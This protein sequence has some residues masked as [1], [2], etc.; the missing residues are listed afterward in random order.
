MLDGL[1]SAYFAPEIVK[2]KK[3][4]LAYERY[5]TKELPPIFI[6]TGNKD[7]IHDC[8]VRLDGYMIAKGL[9]HVFRNYGDKKHPAHHVFMISQKDPLA[10]EA[11]DDEVMFL[12]KYLQK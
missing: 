10:K 1:Q 11:N 5:L 9:T 6:A 2:D 12:K 4:Q 7:M 3:E 8:S